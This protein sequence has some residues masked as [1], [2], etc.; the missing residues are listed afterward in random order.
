MIVFS[1]FDTNGHATARRQAGGPGHIT[2]DLPADPAVLSLAR[3]TVA[4]VA[5]RADLGLEDVDDLRLAVEELCLSMWR[6]I[7]HDPVRL[8]FRFAW[9]PLCVEVAC[10]FVTDDAA[11][12]SIDD[13]TVRGDVAGVHDGGAP[14]DL[15]QQILDALV[16]DH[17]V[18]SDGD[19][20]SGWVRK[21]RWPAPR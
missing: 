4:V 5:A 20:L 12:R 18:I 9:E 21:R 2:L 16:D 1:R 6:R 15:S 10:S 8:L 3:L 14:E 17:G 13:G 11:L 7:E 19:G